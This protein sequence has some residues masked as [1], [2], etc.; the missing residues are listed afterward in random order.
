MVTHM[1][2]T[3]D[4]ADALL[5]SAKA[6]AERERTTL[7]ALVEEGLQEVLKKREVDR[8]P[9]RFRDASV[10]GQGLQPGVDV[11]DWD[12]MLSLIYEGRGG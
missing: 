8:P 6:T 2:T 10:G 7:R 3:I 11:T 9:F 12:R 1:K 4:I 5:E